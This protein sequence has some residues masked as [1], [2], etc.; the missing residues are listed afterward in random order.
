[1]TKKSIFETHTCQVTMNNIQLQELI[2]FVT[3]NR[4]S[5]IINDTKPLINTKSLTETPISKLYERFTLEEK[6]RIFSFLKIPLG[7]TYPEVITF[8]YPVLDLKQLKK[9]SENLY[10]VISLIPEL[11]DKVLFNA[12]SLIN[13]N[14]EVN[15][16]FT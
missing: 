1:M 16:T 14:N 7:I 4:S 15:N 5:I 3:K 13:K 8:S 11:T 10:K 12:T 9:V 6:Y 2:N